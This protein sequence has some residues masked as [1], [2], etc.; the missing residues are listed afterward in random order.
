MILVSCKPSTNSTAKSALNTMDM[1]ATYSFPTMMNNNSQTSCPHDVKVC[2][3][4]TKFLAQEIAYEKTVTLTNGFIGRLEETLNNDMY[5][6]GKGINWFSTTISK[7]YRQGDH[8][9]LSAALFG[10]KDFTT[11]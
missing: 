11:A 6:A 10:S 7:D 3:S 9:T 1:F 4:G 2:E 5:A 8:A